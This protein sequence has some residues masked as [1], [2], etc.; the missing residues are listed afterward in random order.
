MQNREK[1]KEDDIIKSFRQLSM[2]H[3]PDK[4]GNR[5]RFEEIVEAKNKCIEYIKLSAKN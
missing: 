3:H 4:G 5:D 2:Q 1:V